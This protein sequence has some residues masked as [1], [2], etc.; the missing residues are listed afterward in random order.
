MIT[1]KK[2]K[3]PMMIIIIIVKKRGRRQWTGG[4]R[5]KE[6][7]KKRRTKIEIGCV[8]CC[9][10]SEIEKF[11]NSLVIVEVIAQR[12]LMRFDRAVEKWLIT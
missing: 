11:R 4:K 1:K 10:N 6:R 3:M 8:R 9:R 7:E 2:K 5:K 12:W